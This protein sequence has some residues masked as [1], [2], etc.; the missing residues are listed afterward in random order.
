MIRLRHR[1][2]KGNGSTTASATI[3]FTLAQSAAKRW[4]KLTGHHHIQDLIHG[5]RFIDGVNE[6]HLKQ[7]Q[8]NLSQ[9]HSLQAELVA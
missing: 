9:P 5:V 2:T 7:E 8:S 1:T 6:H 4:R 3:R